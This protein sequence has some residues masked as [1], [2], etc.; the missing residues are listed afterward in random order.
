MYGNEFDKIASSDI[1]LVI[2]TANYLEEVNSPGPLAEQRKMAKALKRPVLLMVDCHLSDEQRSQPRGL[3]SEFDIVREIAFDQD[4]MD[5]MND[6]LLEVV[7]E[8]RIL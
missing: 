5:D 1:F 4:A 8:F 7:R 2:G 6:K 3:Y